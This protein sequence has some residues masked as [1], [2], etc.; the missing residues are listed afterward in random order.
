MRALLFLSLCFVLPLQ[1]ANKY[2]RPS[3][4]GS[5]TGADWDNAW[6]IANLNAN[7]GSLSAGDTVWLAGGSYTTGLIFTQSGSGSDYIYFKSVLPTDSVPTSAAGWSAS[8]ACSTTKVHIAPVASSPLDFQASYI[9]VDGRTNNILTTSIAQRRADAL[10]FGVIAEYDNAAD[11]FLGAARFNVGGVHDCV[12]TNVELS[13]PATGTYATPNNFNYDGDNAPVLFRGGSGIVTNITIAGCSLHSGVNLVWTG[14]TAH[15]ITFDRCV[16][17]DNSSSDGS[18]HANIMYRDGGTNWTIRYCDF[19]GWQVEGIV[20]RE[21]GNDTAA[22]YVYGNIF[23][24]PASGSPTCFWPNADSN[25]PQGPLFLYN[26]TFVNV[27]VTSGQA[28]S[29]DFSASS[30]SRNNIFWNSTLAANSDFSG[31]SANYD[32]S[33]GS[34]PGANSISSGSLP[35]TDTNGYDFTIVST[36]SATYPR[37]K[38]VNLGS[39]Y[40]EDNAGNTRGDDGTWDMG[41][42]EFTPPSAVDTLI[43][44]GRI[45]RIGQ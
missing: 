27:T 1:A 13:G 22:H 12:V 4:A 38:G 26:N 29:W 11:S 41:A 9:Y 10:Y 16:F 8:F 21:V 24:D 45:A 15:S 37:D 25:V 17:Y 2:V 6:S 3:S 42:F 33:S 35:F 14:G 31:A 43:I 5:A 34:T 32:F 28:D 40:D 19:T 39:T 36:I 18:L 20:M 30:E 23:H 44:R 7:M